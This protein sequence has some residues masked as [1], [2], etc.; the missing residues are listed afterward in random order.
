[1]K[2][3]ILI[4]PYVPASKQVLAQ[5]IVLA[6]RAWITNR[7]CEHSRKNH[8][9]PVLPYMRMRVYQII[10]KWANKGGVEKKRPI[11][12]RNNEIYEIAKKAKEQGRECFY[13][14]KVE[15]QGCGTR[16]I[17]VPEEEV[18]HCCKIQFYLDEE[19]FEQYADKHL[20][21][22]IYKVDGFFDFKYIMSERV[23]PDLLYEEDW[24]DFWYNDERIAV[25]FRPLPDEV[26]DK[27]TDGL[28]LL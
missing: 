15:E 1:M 2:Q 21:P 18:P 23:L 27:I 25:G 8:L 9:L 16:Y 12:Y 28:K 24:I 26:A 17:E 11:L 7:M 6:G 3:I 19:V 10:P 13:V 22:T 14:K 20:V 4:N 5:F